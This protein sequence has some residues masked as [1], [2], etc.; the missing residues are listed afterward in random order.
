MPNL[1]NAPTFVNNSSPALNATNMNNLATCA[2]A[3]QNYPIAITLPSSGWSDGSITVTASGVKTTTQGFLALAQNAT[4]TQAN[5][6]GAALLR[7]TS[8][9]TNSITLAA[10]GIIPAVDIPVVIH[11]ASDGSMNTGTIV[12]VMPQ[13]RDYIATTVTLLANGWNASNKQT[14]SVTG[15]TANSL[16]DVTFAPASAVEYVESFVICESQ[17]AGSLTFSCQT[18][19]ANDL[20]ANVVI[21]G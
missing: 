2:A 3:N 20:T 12:A 14:V 7:V 18:V 15:V 11:V 16:V 6:A 17:A 9:T 19:P 8:Q 1:Y 5:A 4:A 13:A 10:D 21:R